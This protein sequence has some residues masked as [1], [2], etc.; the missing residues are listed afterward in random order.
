LTKDILVQYCDLR[1]EVKDLRRRIE[2]LEA[3]IEKIEDERY[4][5]D[6]VTGGYGGTQHYVIRGFPYPEYSRKKTRLYLNKAQLE[7]AEQ[8][9]LEMINTVEDYIQS[10][11]DSRIRRIIRYRFIDNLTWVQVAIK[12]GGK[13]TEESARKEFERYFYSE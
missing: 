3:D 4:V 13:T 6:T 11:S 8:E 2:K 5:T 10:I 12:M 9:L 7:T 1:E